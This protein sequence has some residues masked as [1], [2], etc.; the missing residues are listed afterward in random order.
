MTPHITLAQYSGPHLH[1]ADFTLERRAAAIDLL[2]AANAVISLAGADGV[3]FAINPATDSLVSGSGNGGFRP[4]SSRI[5]AP[6]SSHKQGAAVDVYDPQRRFASWC[7]YHQ[8]QLEAAGI[9]AVEDPRWTPTWVHLDRRPR[10]KYFF[11]PDSS[12]PRVGAVPVWPAG[13]VAT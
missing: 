12:P 9:A 1:S 4:Q 13:G 10:L 7:W 8:A 2:A 11:V 6:A 3:A 5:G